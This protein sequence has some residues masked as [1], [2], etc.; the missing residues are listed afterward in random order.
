MGWF[1]SSEHET[2]WTTQ[3]EEFEYD[4]DAVYD[5]AR[6]TMRELDRLKGCSGKLRDVTRQYEGDGNALMRYADLFRDAVRPDI[7][8]LTRTLRD[9]SERAIHLSATVDSMG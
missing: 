4:I 8:E 5:L 9:A 6:D 2:R 3:V 7:D 1:G